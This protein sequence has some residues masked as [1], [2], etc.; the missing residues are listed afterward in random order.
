MAIII[1][2]LEACRADLFSSADELCAKYPLP[3]AERVMRL[4]EMYNYWLANPSMKDRQLRDQIMSRYDVSQSTAYADIA[5][6]HQLV[7]LLSDNTNREY[8]R[9]RAIEMALETYAMAKARKDTKTMERVISTYGKI[10]QLD[11]PDEF[12]P[13]Y[14]LIPIQPWCA[15]TDPS[16]LGIQPIPDYYNYVSR[17]TKDLLRDH[18][19]IIDVEYEEPDLEESFL[20]PESTNA[21]DQPQS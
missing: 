16:V 12:S 7:P 18:R 13:Q 20:F 14:D 6:I 21:P 3:L 19:D 5:I 1:S 15:T 17:L 8:H 4:R 2:P 11:K 9:A 10:T